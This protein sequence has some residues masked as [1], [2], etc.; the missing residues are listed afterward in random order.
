MMGHNNR[1]TMPVDQLFVLFTYHH[2]SLIFHSTST[3]RPDFASILTLALE[4]Y[5]CKTKK[6]LLN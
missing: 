6:D 5:K 2:L 1:F 4:S 3:S